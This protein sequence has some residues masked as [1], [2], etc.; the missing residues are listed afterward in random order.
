MI[1]LG[2]VPFLSSC[3]SQ[4]DITTLN[5]HVRSINKK[6]DD[7]KVNT[8]DQMQQRQASS[9]G[10]LD[11]LQ[12]DILQLKSR[13]EE[14]AHMSRMLQEQNKEFQ[15]A[16][17]SLQSNQKEQVDKQMAEL[18]SKIALQQES[19]TA[20]QHA[21]VEDAE[22]RS[23]AAARAAEDAMRKAQ[24]ASIEQAA[25]R[26]TGVAHLSQDSRKILFSTSTAPAR[27]NTGS[28]RSPATVQATAP[29]ASK[30]IA[31]KTTAPVEVEA[32]DSYAQAQ[33]KFRDGQFKE[34]FN[35]F[36]EEAAKK[37]SSKSAITARYMMGECL[38]KQGE[39]DQA[40]IQYQQI[41]SNFPGNPQA[42]TA[43][44]RQGEAFEQLSDNE[45][46][47]IIYKK[48]AASYG[49]SPEAVT[50]KKRMSSL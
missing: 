19:L 7:M 24:Q 42:A 47:K 4:Q 32:L 40:I 31:A 50:A 38:F 27:T 23:K 43:L 37:G 26:R 33:Q 34:A 28:T 30:P 46:A 11:Q 5:Y 41:I 21:R 3:A 6:L 44:L 35:L 14:N 36:E 17:Q 8:V 9:S 13:L 10:M 18:D 16:L 49:S 15:L 20:I 22:R 2:L 29:V 39:Y 12:A 25:V 48:L 1:L 45:T